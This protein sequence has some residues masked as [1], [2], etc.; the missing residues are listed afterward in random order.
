MILTK[1]E[2][3]NLDLQNWRYNLYK[4]AIKSELFEL[5]FEYSVTVRRG[6]LV[7][8]ARASATQ[9]QGR[10]LARCSG[11][12]FLATVEGSG[13]RVITDAISEPN[14][15]EGGTGHDGWSLG[16][17]TAAAMAD[18]GDARWHASQFRPRYNLAKGA[19]AT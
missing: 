6:P 3:P 14:R 13:G 7:S 10:E 17:W 4:I 16:A 12:L 8:W 19:R 5:S 9:K 1:L 11:E 2:P 15:A 18:S